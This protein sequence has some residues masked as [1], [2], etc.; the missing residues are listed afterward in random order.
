MVADYQA[1]RRCCDATPLYRESIDSLHQS[2]ELVSIQGDFSAC[3]VQRRL[4]FLLS[5]LWVIMVRVVLYFVAFLEGDV[6][7]VSPPASLLSLLVGWG[8]NAIIPSLVPSSYLAGVS[9]TLWKPVPPLPRR[10]NMVCQRCRCYSSPHLL[11]FHRIFLVGSVIPGRKSTGP[12]RVGNKIVR[13]S[14]L[15]DS[16]PPFM[17]LQKYDPTLRHCPF[18]IYYPVEGILLFMLN[19]ER[20]LLGLSPCYEI[21]RK[22]HSA[23]LFRSLQERGR[24]PWSLESSERWS[25]SPGSWGRCCL[26]RASRGTLCTLAR[27]AWSVGVW[28]GVSCTGL[29]VWLPMVVVVVLQLVTLVLLFGVAVVAGMDPSRGVSV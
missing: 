23:T 24:D 11:E 22:C 12:R 1:Y 17:S 27:R 18:E 28:W 2:L 14:F 9:G 29:L 25:G 21:I 20:N 5:F 3:H 7:P 8:G 19:G 6:T 10:K 26:S 16:R 15:D 13:T 4:F